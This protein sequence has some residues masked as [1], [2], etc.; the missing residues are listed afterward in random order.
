MAFELAQ[1]ARQPYPFQLHCW[2]QILGWPAVRPIDSVLLRCFLL[3]ILLAIGQGK[4]QPDM[5]LQG[6]PFQ[7]VAVSC[8]SKHLHSAKAWA[9]QSNSWGQ[10]KIDYSENP[11]M[12]KCKAW[13]CV[14]SCSYS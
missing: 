9:M 14:P 3:A 10:H 13:K 8:H 1:Q 2:H 4:Q 7:F 6:I 5:K 11:S 12:Y